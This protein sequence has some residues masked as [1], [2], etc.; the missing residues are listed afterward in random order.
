MCM[1]CAAV[2]MC[3]SCIPVPHQET[4]G[5]G[6]LRVALFRIKWRIRENGHMDRIKGMHY[7]L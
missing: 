7:I 1:A 5:A 4:A 2:S 3:H 6:A